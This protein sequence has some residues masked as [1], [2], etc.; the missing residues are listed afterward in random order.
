MLM[1]VLVVCLHIYILF[2][3]P[4]LVALGSLAAQSGLLAVKPVLNTACVS[5]TVWSVHSL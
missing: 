5:V 2:P 1:L 4:I 3:H